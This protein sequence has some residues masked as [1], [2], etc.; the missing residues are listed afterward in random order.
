MVC[1]KTNDREIKI[2][3]IEK[4]DFKFPLTSMERGIIMLL[5]NLFYHE[6]LEKRGEC[7]M[8][9]SRFS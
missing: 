8:V 7:G 6:D 5:S 4:A 9:A 1:L 2:F 3:G